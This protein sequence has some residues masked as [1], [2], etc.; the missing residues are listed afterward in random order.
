MQEE[1]VAQIY[2][3]AVHGP[4]KNEFVIEY[5]VGSNGKTKYKCKLTEEFS[6][7]CITAPGCIHTKCELPWVFFEFD[8]SAGDEQLRTKYAN[9][10]KK[11]EEL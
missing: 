5:C 2:R 4:I 1:Y 10:L 7:W 3:T 6:K 8:D 9:N 11:V